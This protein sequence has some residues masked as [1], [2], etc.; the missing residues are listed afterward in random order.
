MLLDL[1][2]LP[3]DVALLHR[4]V[5]DLSH[6]LNKQQSE[7]TQT[8]AELRSS[9]S[10]LKSNAE[11][12]EWLEYQL[13]QLRQ[14]RF[15]KSSQKLSPDQPALWQSELDE[16]IAEAETALAQEKAL[17]AEP[18]KPEPNEV[19]K[20]KPLPVHLPR[21]DHVHTLPCCSACHSELK[22]IGEEVVEQLDYR[23]ASFFVRRHAKKKYACGQCDTAVTA[24][25]PA[26]PIEK[27]TA[28]PG[29]AGPRC[30]RQV[31]RSSR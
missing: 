10:E 5:R 3:N 6:P 22:E 8:R 12:I 16:Q 28:R 31:L 1:N 21:E 4:L 17:H 11:R 26:Q 18:A 23:P 27:G 19:P 29:L 15:G 13:A 20:R 30:R 9:R 2:N 7:L 14:A 25:L 24:S